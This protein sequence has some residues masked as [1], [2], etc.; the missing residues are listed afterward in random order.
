[1]AAK[2]RTSLPEFDRQW[3]TASP[4]CLVATAAA[5]GNCDVSPERPD[6]DLTELER[7]YG[8][9]YQETIYR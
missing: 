9:T 1:V 4:F 5:E 7:C 8:P 2:T 6:D 3:L